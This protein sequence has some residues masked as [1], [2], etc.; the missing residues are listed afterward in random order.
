MIR[1]LQ[2]KNWF[3]IFIS[4]F[5]Y[6]WG[7]TFYILI[8]ITSITFN[9]FII[10]RLLTLKK[11]TNKKNTLNN[12]RSQK[13][14]LL[15]GVILNISAI[16][17]YKYGMFLLVNINTIINIF[18][19]QSIPTPQ[20]IHLPI[21][22]SFFTFQSISLLM[23]IYRN[24]IKKPY[25]NFANVALYI[26]FFP[27]LIA[28]PIIRYN[29]IAN[30]LLYRHLALPDIAQ[31]IVRFI[32][33]LAKKV[34]IANAMGELCDQIMSTSYSNISTPLAWIGI[35][36]Y[37]LQIYFDFSG[38]SD[39]AIGL[40]RMFGFNYPENFKHPYFS[41]SIRDFWHKWHISLSTWF[42]DYLYIPLGGSNKSSFITYLNLSI[43]FL[44]CGLWHG[45]S[46]NFVLWGI[47]HG[48]F[49]ICERI[50]YKKPP[51]RNIATYCYTIF[52]VMI[53]WLIF[54]IDDTSLLINYFRKI[55][56]FEQNVNQAFYVSMY[57]TNEKKLLMIIGIVLSFPI[58]QW[59]QNSPHLSNILSKYFKYNTLY[60][61]YNICTTTLL[62][63]VFFICCMYIATDTYNPFIYFRF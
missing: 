47:W 53:G 34:I 60:P 45:A 52:V 41:F 48:F 36:A 6:A 38:Y 37:T 57:F 12:L 14:I 15:F 24:D 3:L 54:R 23:D 46:W 32:Q 39:M 7:E 51:P 9:F 5:F 56:L 26:S 10:K 49:L 17:Y 20:S 62:Y 8:M 2:L 21:G 55:F 27:Q 19:I 40:G 33:G 25:I 1:P 35:V 44:L 50:I 63:G 61:L 22:I 58:M 4:L 31:G 16:A 28:G 59:Y 11:R 30:A 29:H 18:G 13:L 43:V 42:R